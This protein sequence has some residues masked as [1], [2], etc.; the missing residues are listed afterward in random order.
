MTEVEGYKQDEWLVNFKLV[1]LLLLNLIGGI[2]GLIGYKWGFQ[3]T[4]I[5]LAIGSSVYLILLAAWTVYTGV[6][7]CNAFFR[8][9]R[10]GGGGGHHLTLLW[11]QSHLDTDPSS[12]IYTLKFLESKKSGGGKLC[13]FS[14]YNV[15][16]T[17]SAT[18]LLSFPITNWIYED[19][20][21][22]VAA[23]ATDAAKVASHH[24]SSM[25]K[26]H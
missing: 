2:T 22:D 25:G 6:I 10:S 3:A 16:E 5:P 9:S 18:T 14:K 19:G 13:A 11:L 4:K 21:V 26:E 20:R 7:V 12:P 15:K 8:G 1:S 24:R 17:S 23:F